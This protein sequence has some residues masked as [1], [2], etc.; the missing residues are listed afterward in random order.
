MANRF[1]KTSSRTTPGSI[2]Y[3]H[4]LIFYAAAADC[5]RRGVV[6]LYCGDTTICFYPSRDDESL[7]MQWISRVA[8][9]NHEPEQ[10]RSQCVQ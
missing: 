10:R 3:Q 2:I 7:Y 6:L 9:G 8:A 4:N 5:G 1:P